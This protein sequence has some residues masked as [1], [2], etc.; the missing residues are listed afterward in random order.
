MKKEH[1]DGRCCRALPRIS[2]DDAL[3][4]SSR[5]AEG[6][7]GFD[8]ANRLEG[9]TRGTARKG[10]KRRL[11]RPRPVPH[12][13]S[14]PFPPLALP[15]TAS[16]G[17]WL[18]RGWSDVARAWPFVSGQLPQPAACPMTR[19][20]TNSHTSLLVGRSK[21]EGAN[22]KH[23]DTHTLHTRLFN[24]N[25]GGRP[26]EEGPGLESC[27]GTGQAGSSSSQAAAHAPNTHT[28]TTLLERKT[29]TRGNQR[30][31]DRQRAAN[32]AARGRKDA[33]D[34]DPTKRREA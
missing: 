17:L 16:V 13:L 26:E 3:A 25:A 10:P 1:H 11:G 6:P 19:V 27:G 14:R 31:I 9:N 32:R 12:T 30:E 23:T 33:K 18:V 5:S 15:P 7:R 24:N 22:P 34:G 4:R 21:N 8:A 2:Y 20:G 28:H 29:M